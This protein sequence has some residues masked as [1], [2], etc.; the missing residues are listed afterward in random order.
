MLASKPHI[1]TSFGIPVDGYP[2]DS[3]RSEV[4]ASALSMVLLSILLKFFNIPKPNVFIYIDSSSTI[5]RLI[6]PPRLT[7]YRID[8]P[9]QDL[10]T[11]LS[12]LRPHTC[13]NPI[14]IKSH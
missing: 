14:K 5:S 13:L 12:S 8:M 4:T 7:P 10:F 1:L 2:Q 3:Y 11:I 6:K 9:N